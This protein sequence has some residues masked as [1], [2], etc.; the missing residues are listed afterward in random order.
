MPAPFEEAKHPRGQGGK[1]A[2]KGGSDEEERPEAQ[3]ARKPRVQPKGVYG[4]APEPEPTPSQKSILAKQSA[5]YVGAEIQRYSEEHCEPQLA[6]GLKEPGT[7]ALSL[8]DNEP[9]DV[10]RTQGGKITDGVELKTIT[11]GANEKLTMKRSALERK[12]AWQQENGAD[13]HTACFDD[14]KVFNAKGAGQHDESQRVIYYKRGAGSFRLSSMHRCRD[15]AELRSLMNTP[16]KDL[17]RA[18][19]PPTGY[20]SFK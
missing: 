9:V 14:R 18:A 1:F 3:P 13:F 20:A 12:S 6:A 5:R 4:A 8:R 11:T 16:T 7:N 2:P 19:Q 10:I 15:M 17:P